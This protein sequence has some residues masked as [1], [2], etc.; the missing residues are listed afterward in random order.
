MS[1]RTRRKQ[2]NPERFP[3]KC[4]RGM[5]RVCL[6][7]RDAGQVFDVFD[8]RKKETVQIWRPRTLVL[9][10]EKVVVAPDSLTGKPVKTMLKLY[11]HDGRQTPCQLKFAAQS[12]EAASSPA[13]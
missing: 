3:R 1:V 5:L 8:Q 7:C 4:S 12:K 11:M 13:G 10:G 2:P 6:M 9:V